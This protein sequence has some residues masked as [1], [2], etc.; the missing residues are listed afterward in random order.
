MAEDSGSG[1]SWR[2][3]LLIAPKNVEA[4]LRNPRKWLAEYIVGG[5]IGFALFVA[6]ILAQPFEVVVDV[7][8]SL[9]DDLAT[10]ARI[11]LE[12]GGDLWSNVETVLYAVSTQFGPFAP[13][14]TAVLIVGIIIVML[15]L[16]LALLVALEELAGSI[17]VIGGAIS[18]T[19]K[20]LRA[21]FGGSA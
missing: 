5:I 3:I 11:F 15:R 18:G 1:L 19:T 16:M 8:G 13:V 2:K 17:P 6:D 7:L 4:L 10:P 9:G 20:A 21:L 14:V 12:V